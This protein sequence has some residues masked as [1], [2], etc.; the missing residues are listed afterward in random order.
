MNATLLFPKL[1]RRDQYRLTRNNKY[2]QAYSAYR[3]EIRE[4]CLGRCVY[5]DCHENHLG[6]Q[7]SMNLDHFRPKGLL[8]FKY[9]IND[10]NNL[11]WCCSR[12]NGLKSDRWPAVGTDLTFL[13]DEGFIDPFTENRL[14]YFSI[15]EDGSLLPLKPPAQYMIELLGLNLFPRK[16]REMRLQSHRLVKK[17]DE[18]VA[19]LNKQT[20]LSANEISML[21]LLQESR[22]EHEKVLDFKLYS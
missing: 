21:T 22:V 10:P 17:I 9:L 2:Y 6:G 7:E 19:Y 8:E 15:Q 12:C 11:L 1:S 4:D 14:D 3:Q 18:A 13:N 20:N 16:L 5:C